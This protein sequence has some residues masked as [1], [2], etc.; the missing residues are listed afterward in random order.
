MSELSFSKQ[1]VF[2]PWVG[3]DY[4]QQQTKVLFLGES[5]YE[6]AADGTEV[7]FTTEVI[8]RQFGEGMDVNQE[9]ER[10]VLQSKVE[11][12]FCDRQDLTIDGTKEFWNRYAFYNFV[13]GAIESSKHRPTSRQFEDSVLPFCEVLNELKPNL[14]VILGIATWNNLPNNESLQ[15]NKQDFDRVVPSPSKKVKRKLEL[16]K[17]TAMH[18]K[19]QHTFWCFY[20]P[21]PSSIGFGAA[22]DWA[23]WPRVALEEIASRA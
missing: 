23:D 7:G 1:I 3:A 9:Y 4:F 20:I 6:V 16:W 5:H 19:C 12:M 13:Q 21:H 17:G 22:R 10:Y 8:K 2:A 11:R 14:V 15:W 18:E